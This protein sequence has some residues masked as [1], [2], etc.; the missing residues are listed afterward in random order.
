MDEIAA[1]VWPENL[2][3]VETFIA[4]STQW[5]FGYAGPIGLDYAALPAVFDIT[6]VPALDRADAFEGLR[7]MESEALR[8]MGEARG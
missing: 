6:G 2:L 3:A 7:V 8:I 5:R 4:M 1:D